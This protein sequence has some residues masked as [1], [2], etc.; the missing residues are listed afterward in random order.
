[1]KPLQRGP[2][3]VFDSGYG[4]LTIL[5]ALRSAL[6]EYD[7]LYLGDNARSPYG[8]RSFEVV[9]RFTLQAVE[10][11]FRAGAPLI[12]L[13]CNT[14]SAK[15]LR[16]IQQ[17]Y[18][19]GSA[20]PTRRILGIIRP[21]V[22][23]VEQY[24]HTGHIGVVAT[25]GTVS[26]DSYPLEIAKLFPQMTVTQQ[27]CPM[28]V[29]LVENGEAHRPGADYFV[30]QYIGQLLQRDSEIDTLLLACTHYPLLLD[31]IRQYTPREI[32]LVTQGQLVAPSLTDYLG[33]HPEM[34]RRLSKGGG[35]RFLTSEN[36]DKFQQKASLFL[37]EEVSA[38]QV[39][40]DEILL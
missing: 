23:A 6:P 40:I 4:G 20:D 14:A 11:L 26:S 15:A 5:H 12:I 29:P 37:A 33:R 8:S 3:A 19:P 21:T 31:K 1:M 16:C 17:Q 34:E 36:A 24:T 28:W 35:I 30:Q 38:E 10:Y 27:A 25:E 7:Y 2:I 18:L 22:E 9:Y 39:S 32:S 13:A